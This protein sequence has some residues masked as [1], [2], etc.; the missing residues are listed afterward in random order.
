MIERE[1]TM[2]QSRQNRQRTAGKSSVDPL[3]RLSDFP[4]FLSADIHMHIRGAAGKRFFQGIGSIRLHE[5]DHIRLCYGTGVAVIILEQVRIQMQ[6]GKLQ[7]GK[8]PAFDQTVT[9]AESRTDQ[10]IGKTGR[11]HSRAFNQ[12][13]STDVI[14]LRKH[15]G[16][17]LRAKRKTSDQQYGRAEIL[18]DEGNDF[19]RVVFN[20]SKG[21][22]ASGM[23]IQNRQDDMLVRLQKF[24]FPAVIPPVHTAAVKQD[25][26]FRL[27]FAIFFV[28]HILFSWKYYTAEGKVI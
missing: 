4:V 16:Q 7:L 11:N 24:R 26:S 14:A 13:M 18:I 28:I 21:M 9:A 25:D 22:V 6:G 10:G 8:T 27:L 2:I 1:F 5:C 17:D 15:F 19:R 23:A 12:R 20:R 3:C